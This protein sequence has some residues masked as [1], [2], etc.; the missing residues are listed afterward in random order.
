MRSGET[1][2]VTSGEFVVED[3]KAID[4][5][6]ESIYFMTSVLYIE[7]NPYFGQLYRI[8]FKGQNKKLLTPG[9]VN[10]EVYIAED[11]KYFVDNQS[12]AQDPTRSVLRSEDGS[13]MMEIDRAEISD[14][15]DLG[16]L[17][18]QEFTALA[19]DGETPI[20]GALWKPTDFDET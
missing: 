14:L 9:R 20:Y 1:T 4:E 6:N 11:Y 19:R 16:W 13:T 5:D 2:P 12:T 10:H 17:P 18:P 7:V 3:I 8:D 15:E